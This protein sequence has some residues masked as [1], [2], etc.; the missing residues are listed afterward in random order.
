MVAPLYSVCG[1]LR[2]PHTLKK[3]PYIIIYIKY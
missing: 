1:I 3:E 2:I